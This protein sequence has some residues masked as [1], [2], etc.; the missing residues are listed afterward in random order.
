MK[1]ILKEMSDKT[2]ELLNPHQNG[3]PITYNHY[4]TETLQKV[5]RE[6]S[7]EE[8]KGVLRRFFQVD[9]LQSCYL[10][11]DKLYNLENLADLLA[12]TGEPDMKRFAASEAMDC[13]DAYYKVGFSHQSFSNFGSCFLALPP[14]SAAIFRITTFLGSPRLR[15]VCR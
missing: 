13:L 11:D 14:P 5:R 12:E 7:K 4:F 1:D 9:S 8:R 3:H 10:S 15:G 2:S 6:R